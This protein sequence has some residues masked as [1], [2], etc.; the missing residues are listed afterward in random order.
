MSDKDSKSIASRPTGELTRTRPGAAAIIDR[1]IDDATDIL[2]R[3]NA[4]QR[5]SG[6]QELGET[7]SRNSDEEGSASARSHSGAMFRN[8]GT[9]PR[10][11]LR[12]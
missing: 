8:C 11:T 1:M 4:G 3:R 6:D 7:D 10:M 2:R 5:M 12:R 9:F